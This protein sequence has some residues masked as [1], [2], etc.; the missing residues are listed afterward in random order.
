MLPP[1]ESPAAPVLKS[2][3]WIDVVRSYALPLM[4]DPLVGQLLAGSTQAERCGEV[5]MQAMGAWFRLGAWRIRHRSGG[6]VDA[7]AVAAAQLELIDRLGVLHEYAHN[8]EG[9]RRLRNINR[10]YADGRCELGRFPEAGPLRREAD[11]PMD[12]WLERF[13][14]TVSCE[15]AFSPRD[16]LRRGLD[17]WLARMRHRPTDG[18]GALGLEQVEHVTQAL[19]WLRGLTERLPG[20]QR[21]TITDSDSPA[22]TAGIEFQA[23]LIHETTQRRIL[24]FVSTDPVRWQQVEAAGSGAR[25]QQVDRVIDDVVGM[26]GGAVA[27]CG[28]SGFAP[29]IVLHKV[30]K[31]VRRRDDAPLTVWHPLVG[32]ADLNVGLAA[33]A[34]RTAERLAESVD[35]M[36]MGERRF[37]ALLIA[38]VRQLVC[39]TATHWAGIVAMLGVLLLAVG[40]TWLALRIRLGLLADGTPAASLEAMLRT[41]GSWLLVWAVVAGLTA[42]IGGVYFWRRRLW[43]PYGRCCVIMRRLMPSTLSM[44]VAHAMGFVRKRLGD[45][46]IRASQRSRDVDRARAGELLAELAQLARRVGYHGVLLLLDGVPVRRENVS[47]HPWPGLKPLARIPGLVVLAAVEVDRPYTGFDVVRTDLKRVFRRV[48]FLGTSR[49]ETPCG[50]AGAASPDLGAVRTALAAAAVHPAWQE[51]LASALQAVD[52][53]LLSGLATPELRAHLPSDYAWLPASLDKL[54]SAWHPTA[55]PVT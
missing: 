52:D 32:Q 2:L 36:E 17:R 33:M 25:R 41:C 22:V 10:L 40:G 23:R 50:P 37:R 20:W 29:S 45:R 5:L 48:H 35:R 30:A 44:L 28:E 6:E 43:G 34:A 19:L 49:P 12:D 46:L 27:V 9:T 54:M 26:D 15:A 42:A 13:A 31:G 4:D 55:R 11:E 14:H 21:K 47:W 16:F 18:P 8:S 53:D 1:T 3:R 51:P 38:P 39:W 7:D 24:S